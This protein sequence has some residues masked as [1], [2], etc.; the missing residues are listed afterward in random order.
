MRTLR[1]NGWLNDEIVNMV[2][3]LVKDF[4]EMPPYDIDLLGKG[5]L[6]D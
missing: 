5:L 3:N 1:D 4:L 6:S 2:S